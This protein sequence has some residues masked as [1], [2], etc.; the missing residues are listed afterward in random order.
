M[1]S[2]WWT[3]LSHNENND[4]NNSCSSGYYG[5]MLPVHL[6]PWWLY[7]IGRRPAGPR[8]Q[9]RALLVHERQ[10]H[11]AMHESNSRGADGVMFVWKRRNDLVNCPNQRV[12]LSTLYICILGKVDKRQKWMRM[13]TECVTFDR[14]YAGAVAH[15]H[16]PTLPLC[17]VSPPLAPLIWGQAE[18]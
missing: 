16:C 12:D 6:R 14:L 2:W 15:S 13:R 11:S 4:R 7:D 9:Y 18:S 10:S 8:W 3:C 17:T 1:W 5:S